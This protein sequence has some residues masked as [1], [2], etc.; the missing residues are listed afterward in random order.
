MSRI[1]TAKPKNRLAKIVRMSRVMLV[2]TCT[3][4][5]TPVLADACRACVGLI[6]EEDQPTGAY[7]IHGVVAGHGHPHVYHLLVLRVIRRHVEARWQL[8]TVHDRCLDNEEG[9][10]CAGYL[11]VALHS[12]RFPHEYRQTLTRDTY[13]RVIESTHKRTMVGKWREDKNESLTNVRGKGM[14]RSALAFPGGAS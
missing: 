1:A 13:G 12:V 8:H 2:Q 5:L 7:L 6:H 11:V 4:D 3:I 10:R 14:G 9:R